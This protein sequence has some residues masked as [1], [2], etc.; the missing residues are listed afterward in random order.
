MKKSIISLVFL[1]TIGFSNAQ[2]FSSFID[3]VYSLPEDQRME[4]VDSFMTII[5]PIGIPYINEDTAN[6]IYQGNAS[7]VQVPGDFN[8]WDPTFFYLANISGTNFWYRTQIFEMNARLDYKFVLDGSTWILDPLNPNQTWG[9]YGPNS[10]LAMPEYIQPWEIEYNTGIQHGTI[11]TDAITSTNTGSTFQLQIYLPVN[12]NPERANPYP[13]AYFQDGHEYISLGSAD[14]VLD[15]L[16]YE[17]HIDSIIGVFVKP[18]NRNEEYAGNLRNEYRLFFVEELVPYIDENHNTIKNPIGRAVIGA[19][20]G[21]NISALISYNHPDVFGFCGLHSGAFWPNNYEAYNLIVQ[22]PVENIKWASIW[23]TYEGLYENMRD[24]R[25]FLNSNGYELK[26]DELPEGHSWGLWRAT[27]DEM[28]TW[29]FPP[30]YSRIFDPE[31]NNQMAVTVYPNPVKNSATISFYLKKKSPVAIDILD[32]N[33]RL[34]SGQ[35]FGMK[36]KGLV[37]LKINTDELS[38]GTY[39]SEISVKSGKG[40][41]KFIKY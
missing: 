14:N 8:G 31:G 25:D 33:G 27:I 26:W 30:G 24:L 13:V 7:T 2:S 18:N 41:Y 1:L 6:F 4:A 10:E 40:F 32:M 11:D 9:G 36:E 17:N 37:E 5:T 21:G 34:K 15:N 38:A 35:D 29:F 20:F 3:Y 19:S 22:G 12:Y 39:L 16:I 28:L 23:G